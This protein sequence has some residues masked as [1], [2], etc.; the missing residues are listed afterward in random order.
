M[1][2]LLSRLSRSTSNREAQPRPTLRTNVKWVGAKESSVGS[3]AN[4]PPSSRTPRLT[5]S[6]IDELVE[7]YLAGERVID[8]ADRFTI[9]RSTVMAHLRRAGVPKYS[10]WTEATTEEARR[11][12]EAGLSLTEISERMGRARTTI[13]NH[14]RAAGVEMRPRGFG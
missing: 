7:S 3:T 4:T 1:V 11:H 12:Y 8:L 6:E 14:L 13:G 9:S 2:D 5:S 10:G